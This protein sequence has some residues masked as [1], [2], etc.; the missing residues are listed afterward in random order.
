M[1]I[2]KPTLLVDEPKV[3]KNIQ[4]ML[5]K[6]QQSNA[7]LRPHFK[8][9]QSASIGKWFQ[10]EGVT[11]ATVSSVDMAQYFAEAGWEDITIAF[12]YNPLEAPEVEALAKKIRLNVLIIS[13]E[14]LDHLNTHVDAELGYFIKV[15]VGTHR[16]GINPDDDKLA[17]Q[18]A[19]SQNPNHKLQGLLAHAGHTYKP[20]DT[21]EAQRIYNQSI[22]HFQYLKNAIGRDDLILSYGDTPSCS[23]LSDFS[24]VDELRP[25][26]FAFYDTMQHYFGSCSLDQ[27]AV[28]MACPVVA[29]H[30]D[31]GEV[32]VYGGGVHLSK[33]VINSPTGRSFGTV[34][35]LEESGWKS[36]PIA[37]VDRLSQ[38]HGIIKADDSLIQKLKIGDLLGILPVHS[39]MAADLQGY[40]VSLDGQRLDKLNKLNV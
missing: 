27:I 9:H 24:K 1:N 25:G 36:K 6:A 26:N 33:D 31:R 16:T 5:T 28:C 19:E 32:V 23:L 7:V 30:A 18:L 29:I 3:R 15:D 22:S 11:K 34:V 2:T 12:P 10:E 17:Q 8:T 20:L 21:A 4:M 40:Y 37:N 14:A 35:E 38:E 13:K 39:C